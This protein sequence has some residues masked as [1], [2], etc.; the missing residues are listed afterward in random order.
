MISLFDFKDISAIP[1]NYMF[2]SHNQIVEMIKN[3]RLD[4]ESRLLFACD[5]ID[6]IK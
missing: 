4:I 5:N 1:K 3:K 2:L 6:H